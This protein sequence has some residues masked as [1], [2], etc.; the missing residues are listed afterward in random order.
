MWPT[1]IFGMKWAAPITAMVLSPVIISAG[2]EGPKD[3][4]MAMAAP[5]YAELSGYDQARQEVA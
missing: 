1:V 5:V 2:A 3:S 4:S